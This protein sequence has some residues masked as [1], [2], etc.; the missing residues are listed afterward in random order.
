MRAH[1]ISFSLLHRTGSFGWC[2]G[3]TI[4]VS[5]I[6]FLFTN[7][8]TSS[9]TAVLA[10]PAAAAFTPV[11]GECWC[12]PDNGEECPSFSLNLYQSFPNAWVQLH[13]S[14]ILT[15]SPITY[16]EDCYP[17]S[18]VDEAPLDPDLYPE[19]AKPRCEELPTTTDTSDSSSLFCAYKYE[20]A[21]T[22][23]PPDSCSDRRYEL[24]TYTN[25]TE[26]PANA[27]IIHTGP[28]GVCSNAND[29]AV[30]M[31]TI[32][33]MSS[34][35]SFC[36]TAYATDT[37][38]ATRFDKLI[39]CFRNPGFSAPCAR[40]WAH[41][42]A[43]N[44]ALCAVQCVSDVGG[45]FFGPPPACELGDCLSCSRDSFEHE[46]NAFAGV[47]KSPYNAGFVDEI[48]YS[49]DLFF[50]TEGLDPCFGTGLTATDPP[51][52][53]PTPESGATPLYCFRWRKSLFVITVSLIYIAYR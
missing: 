35:A 34:I 28:C 20:E 14:S 51:S 11:C 3:R 10:Q 23:V 12:I 31:E 49:C 1:E 13:K 46:F 29:L 53:A 5:S 22:I 26:V 25:R 24:V 18:L 43:T 7:D 42:T 30:R 21:D 52:M 16:G 27:V 17:F 33:Q 45:T 38:F 44:A 50:P 8:S 48:A 36:G 39:A 19:S 2:W 15:S 32:D 9:R 41:F 47:Y 6:L 40:H 37:N 4:F